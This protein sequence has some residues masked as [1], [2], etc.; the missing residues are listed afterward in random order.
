M[1]ITI[2]LVN[3]DGFY[4]VIGSVKNEAELKAFLT[5]FKAGRLFN[6]EITN[7]TISITDAFT[8]GLNLDPK[9]VEALGF[10][11]GLNHPNGKVEV[12]Q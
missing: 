3:E 8:T 5:N 1:S 10:I 4:K 6:A 9:G 11:A 12:E 2:K 7:N